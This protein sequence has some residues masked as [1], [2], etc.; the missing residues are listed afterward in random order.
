M[1]KEKLNM[2]FGIIGIVIGVIWFIHSLTLDPGSAP[3]QTIQYLGFV[4][5]SIFIIGGVII[6]K[7]QEVHK[8]IVENI[9]INNIYEK[10]K[11]IDE[12][13]EI[14][15]EEKLFDESDNAPNV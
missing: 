2:V 12:N 11:N 14:V 8:Y 7:I 15:Y 13:I 10:L 3:Q 9:N 5:S 1:Y 4:C 6:L